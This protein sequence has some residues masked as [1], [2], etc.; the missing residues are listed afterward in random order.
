ML[1]KNILL[2]MNG[3]DDAFLEETA[4]KLGYISGGRKIKAPA[5]YSRRTSRRFAAMLIAACL[6]L[7]LG[8]VAY[9]A[10]LFG[11]RAL[12]IKRDDMSPTR[13]ENG[14]FVSITQPQEV[15]EEMSTE[16]KAKIDNS[17]KAWA[18]WDAWREDNR[19]S[20]PEVFLE[21]E[22]CDMTDIIENGDGTY[23][24]IFRD[25]VLT[26]DDSGEVVDAEYVE[27]ER[28][29][30]TAEEYEREM[31]H[32]LAG[33]QSYPGYDFNYDVTTAEAA[34]KLEEIAAKYGLE[35][36]RERNAMYQNFGSFTQFNSLE[37][38]TAKI[39]EVCAGGKSFFRTEPTGYDKFYYFNE[40]TFAV[41]FFTTDDMTNEGTYCYLYNSPYGTL[42]SGFEIVG[43]IEDADAMSTYTHATPDGT[44]LTVLHNGADMFAYVYLE[45]SFV[46]MSFHQLKGLSADEI[47]A[48][49]DMVDFGVI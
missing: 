40:G 1:E 17:T 34:E 26:H 49:I 27:M 9:A 11:I 2:A 21:P 31:E 25:A 36:R 13:S 5:S 8:L 32:M 45:N 19:P 42:S 28:R 20:R 43:E 22:G 38:I 46:T 39:N 4:R 6:L 18:E 24:V 44:E 30:A 37:E 3:A 16:I 10:D 33:S 12:L 15:P 48:I 35:L 41:S 47:N 7:S 14:A 29:T 23:A